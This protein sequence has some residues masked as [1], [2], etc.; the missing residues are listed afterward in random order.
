MQISKSIQKYL[1]K[2]SIHNWN[3]EVEEN[4]LY[5]NILVIPALDE[6]NNV[7]NL[8]KSL[9]LNS[10]QYLSETLILFIVNNLVLE[11]FDIIENNRKLLIY[12]REQI[13]IDSKLNLGVIDASSVGKELP[14]KNGGVGLARKIGMD[15]AL[16]YFDFT[17]KK[18]KI[19]IS[20]DADCLV[21]NNYLESIIDQFN[22]NNFQVAL[23]NFDHIL[24]ED[25]Q[26]KA[27][28]VN[29][30]IFLRYYVLGLTYAK[31]PFTF[32]SVGSTIVC[33]VES[34]VKVGGM[35]KRKAGED[36][37]FLE[38]LAKAGQIHRIINATVFPSSR[39]SERVPFGTGARIKRFVSNT[40]NE[41]VLYSPKSFEILRKWLELFF[42]IEIKHQTP[43]V[44]TAAIE[45]NSKLYDFL[46]EQNFKSDWDNILK[47]SKSEIQLNKQ[48][49]NWMDGFRTLKLI[50]YL[51]DNENP[52]QDM[53]EAI[54][55]LLESMNV[56]FDYISINQIPTLE[57]QLKYLKLLRSLT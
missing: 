20:L 9:S 3:I 36:F 22:R 55:N 38:K 53:F 52:N 33:D 37:Y 54:N 12:L 41:Y 44:L 25:D 45:I 15:L 19:F 42:S 16:S 46:I 29:Y 14:A 21:S 8:I 49:N 56:N 7:Q 4:R 6:L 24:P 27:A 11:N 48:K 31:S 2:Q 43:F 39:I 57:I 17:N 18:K 51:R 50:H 23:V 13:L 40:H 34:Y 35:N 26:Q 30:E 5:N 1:L 10:S 28:I 47:N 32:P